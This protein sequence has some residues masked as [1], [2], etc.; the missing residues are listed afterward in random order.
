[1]GTMTNPETRTLKEQFMLRMPEGMRDRIKAAA[2]ANNRSMNSEILSLLEERYPEP[3]PGEHLE[4]HLINLAEA[5]AR[6]E[7]PETRQDKLERF[8]SELKDTFGLKVGTAFQKQ[9]RKLGWD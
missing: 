6:D 3:L 2:D 8:R 7:N 4:E 9:N 1:M 5:I